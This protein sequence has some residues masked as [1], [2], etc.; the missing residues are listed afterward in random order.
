MGPARA[1]ARFCSPKCRAKWNRDMGMP[2]QMRKAARWVRNDAQK[3][4]LSA[5]T[6]RMVDVS[7]P[8]SWATFEAAKA[9]PVGA[10]MG[11]VIG[12]NNIGCIDLDHCFRGGQLEPWAREILDQYPDALLVEVSRSGEGLHIFTELPEGDAKRIR[13]GRNI[14]YYPPN[15]VRYVAV[16]GHKFWRD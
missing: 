7:N 14:E 11:Y 5:R 6:G 10:G 4:P 8:E 1:D 2:K 15:S 3:R 16:T 13:D 12:G 9:S